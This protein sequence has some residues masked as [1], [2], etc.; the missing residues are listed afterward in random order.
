MSIT[1]GKSKVGAVFAK[2]NKM[3]DVTFNHLIIVDNFHFQ[4][5]LT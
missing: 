5:L 3:T 2:G 4:L 1:Y